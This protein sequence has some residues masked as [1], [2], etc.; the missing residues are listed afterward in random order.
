MHRKTSEECTPKLTA[1]NGEKDIE[2]CVLEGK[3]DFHCRPTLSKRTI[4]NCEHLKCGQYQ[5]GTE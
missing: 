1:L 3:G 5:K 4:H 2:I